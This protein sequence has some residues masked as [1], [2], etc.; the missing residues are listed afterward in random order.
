[1]FV[2]V[3]GLLEYIVLPCVDNLVKLCDPD[4]LAALKKHQALENLSDRS[5]NLF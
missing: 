5:Q 3:Q 2:S 1:M 4:L